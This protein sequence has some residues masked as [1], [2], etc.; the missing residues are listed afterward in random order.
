MITYLK[1][2]AARLAATAL[3]AL[4]A[5]TLNSCQPRIPSPVDPSQR[6]TAQELQ[7]EL[8]HLLALYELRQQQLAER[9]R[10]R[11]AILANALTIANTGT[12]NPLGVI[13]A[14]AGIYGIGSIAKDTTNAIKKQIS[15]KTPI[16]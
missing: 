14:L 4:L 6:L 7:V 16:V 10:I 3:F 8:N 12:I 9:Q 1:S 5:V 2:H 13:T 15:P 11:N